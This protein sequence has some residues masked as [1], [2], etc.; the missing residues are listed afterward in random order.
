MRTSINE[1]GGGGGNTMPMVSTTSHD[2]I[3][4]SSTGSLRYTA[5]PRRS[6]ME[7]PRLLSSPH[8]RPSGEGRESSRR[9]SSRGG[10]ERVEESEENGRR[11]RIDESCILPDMDRVEAE[12]RLHDRPTG[13]FI[14]RWRDDGISAALSLRAHEG[15]LH[16]KIDRIAERWI[17]GEGARFRSISQAISFYRKNPLPIRGARHICLLECLSVPRRSEENLAR[18]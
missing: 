1:S 9:R 2:C 5:E 7:D 3:S 14:L 12:K 6:D 18:L 11:R 8:F 15:V 17:V 4:S 10:G 16:L 13:D